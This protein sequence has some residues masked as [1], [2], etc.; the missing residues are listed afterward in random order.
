[1]SSNF[2][3]R[4]LRRISSPE[5]WRSLETMWVFISSTTPPTVTRDSIR[6]N[7]AVIRC[8]CKHRYL[9]Y[10]LISDRTMNFDQILA[11]VNRREEAIRDSIIMTSMSHHTPSQPRS[12]PSIEVV[13]N[14]LIAFACNAFGL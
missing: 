12:L 5:P 10:E 14:V 2:M 4:R 7:H 3:K 13:N 11:E 9:Y 6:R 8:L 1:M